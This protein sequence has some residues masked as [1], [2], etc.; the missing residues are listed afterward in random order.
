MLRIA[1]V[2]FVALLLP[3]LPMQ[4]QGSGF[5]ETWDGTPSSPLPWSSPRW[6][7]MPT[8]G[9]GLITHDDDSLSWQDIEA[10]HGPNC[11]APFG[12]ANNNHM[13]PRSPRGSES[14]H[15]YAATGARQ[16][17]YVCN[18]HLMTVMKSGTAANMIIPRYELDWSGGRTQTISFEINPYSFQ[19]EWWELYI[20][21][22]N[23]LTIDT[24]ILSKH[25]VT[26][27]MLSDVPTVKQVD[28][29]RP[30]AWPSGRYKSQKF[31]GYCRSTNDPACG[32]P[33]IRR[34]VT[35]TFNTTQFTFNITKADGSLYTFG[36]NWPRPLNFNS[37]AIMAAHW[38][39][40]PTKDGIL[41]TP[42]S[43]YTYHWD[44]FR[45]DGPAR[46]MM[47]GY[48]P[49]P[50]VWLDTA[51][52]ATSAIVN[53]PSNSRNN[54]RIWG[55]LVE[56]NA[57]NWQTSPVR[58]DQKVTQ[59][60]AQVRI[61]NGL[62]VDLPSV[63]D[64][65]S[66]FATEDNTLDN[67]TTSHTFLAPLDIVQFGN[68]TVEFRVQS[69]GRSFSVEYFEIQTDPVGAPQPMPTVIATSTAA[70]TLVATS[71]P[72]GVITFDDLT[73][74]DR[75]LNGAYATIDWGTNG[76]WLSR[77][78]QAFTT[79]SI[80]FN[81]NGLLQGTFSLA[82]GKRL[83]SIRAYN[84]GTTSTNVTIACPT[85]PTLTM[86]LAAGAIQNFIT[87][88]T[89]S[90][91]S[92]T[93]TTGNGWNTNFDDIT[94]VDGQ[95]V[96]TATL[97]PTST[98]FPSATSTATST[99]APTA[100]PTV[101]PTLIPTATATPTPEPCFDAVIRGQSGLDIVRGTV[102]GCP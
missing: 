44:T 13:V 8:S 80:G 65:N 33:R 99:S 32:D 53:I 47:S 98:P 67:Q 75:V 21:P 100:L 66:I 64:A 68:N 89:S 93:L 19:R 73:N 52:G 102:I 12:G 48:T 78:W 95:V 23:E 92:V 46:Q 26:F 90:C 17:F 31:D 88:W 96:P 49:E 76:W 60:W 34:L 5:L 22:I 70:P 51:G 85:N 43:M 2:T 71:V 42:W 24:H 10:G 81:G 79:N 83:S 16:S 3:S 18:N 25:A 69:P 1:L 50:R 7:T 86:N 82:P 9:D 63:R 45:F 14:G 29:Y 72:S 59:H 20:A 39:Y 40:N 87:Q 11:E 58:T 94:L 101:T 77:P 37:A 27:A 35:I 38:A 91:T 55:V 54:P 36:G 28:D 56:G 84:G 6:I 41:G 57:G 62:W 74:P 61:N 97:A 15:D 4:A 30:L